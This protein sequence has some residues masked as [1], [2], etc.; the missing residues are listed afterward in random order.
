[1][2]SQYARGDYRRSNRS[3]GFVCQLSL[4]FSGAAL[5]DIISQSHFDSVAS[6]ASW[7]DIF[8]IREV[9]IG[10]IAI[11]MVD[12]KAVRFWAKESSGNQEMDGY[13]RS[14]LFRMV[15]SDTGITIAIERR[16]KRRFLLAPPK[17]YR[18]V[19][20]NKT[21]RRNFVTTII[22][23]HGFPLLATVIVCANQGVF[24]L[25]ENIFGE[26]RSSLQRRSSR[27]YFSMRIQ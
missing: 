5:Y 22:P 19:S 4:R 8:K 14:C 3:H 2:S 12:L 21:R 9:V 10:F 17:T 15:K 13:L 24:S 1:M 20:T 6:V 16:A 27:S 26:A 18:D 7:R 23:D 25:S 11:F